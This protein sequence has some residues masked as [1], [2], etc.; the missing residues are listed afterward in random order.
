M[1]GVAK[2]CPVSSV[3]MNLH[4]MHRGKPDLI[5]EELVSIVEQLVKP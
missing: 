1:E 3:Q 4:V 2:S 5:V